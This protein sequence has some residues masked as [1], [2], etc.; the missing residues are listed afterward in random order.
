MQLQDVA[1]HDPAHAKAQTGLKTDARLAGLLECGLPQ[2]SY[3]PAGEL[4]DTRDLTVAIEVPRPRTA[5]CRSK[6]RKPLTIFN[7]WGYRGA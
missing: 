6:T 5:F 7:C 1:A 3:I 4:K 2:G